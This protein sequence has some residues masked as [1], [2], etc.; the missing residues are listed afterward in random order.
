MASESPKVKFRKNRAGEWFWTLVGGNG[1]KE[2]NGEGHPDL[3]GAKVA[4][5]T[6][7]ANAERAEWVVE[8]PTDE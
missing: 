7:L 5:R 8:R 4:W 3:A 6:F 2:G 1:E